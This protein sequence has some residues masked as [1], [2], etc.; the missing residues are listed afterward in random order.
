MKIAVLLTCFNRKEKTLNALENLMQAF[1]TVSEKVSL[2]IYLTDDGSTDGTGEAVRAKYPEAIILQ[3]NGNLYWAGGM[4]NSWREALKGNFDAYLLL[5]DDTNVFE[6]IFQE[7]LSAHE[8]S[9]KQFGSQGI[10][11][12][13]TY[14][15]NTKEISYGGAKLTNK[16]MFKYH[17]LTPNGKFQNCELGNANIM[18]V[19]KEVVNEIGILS[20]GYIHGVADYDYTLKAIQ[21][22]IPVLI[23]P[24][25]SG[26][27]TDDHSDIYMTFPEKTFSER[28]AL[29][30]SPLALDFK[31]NFNLMLRHFPLRV[32]FVLFSAGLKLFMPSIYVKGLR[33]NR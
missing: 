10:Y 15:E 14:D 6:N 28:L 33:K 21:K 31:S 19:P 7:L 18:L 4:R 16:F 26:T 23:T 17:F 22:N 5:N 11:L 13:S 30:K 8:Y 29:L 12:G 27:C 3:G 20:E 25:Y 24:N 1:Y 2:K 32:P 9:L